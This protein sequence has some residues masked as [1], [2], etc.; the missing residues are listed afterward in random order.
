MNLLI[1]HNRQRIQALARK[2]GVH[3]VRLFGSMSRDDA[4]ADS[5]VDLLVELEQGR[6]GLA[7]GGFLQDVSDLLGRRVD[8]VTE[9]ALHPS[10]REQVLHEAV[11]L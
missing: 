4:T 11:P 5:D 2:R 7:L 3:N 9:G 6:S 8:V 1:E 10:I